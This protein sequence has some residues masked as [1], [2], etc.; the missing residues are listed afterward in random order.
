MIEAAWTYSRPAKGPSP[1]AQRQN[2][3][4]RAIADKARHRLTG[5]YRKL[6][7]RGKLAPVAIAAVARE[8]L[9]FIWAIAHAAHPQAGDNHASIAPG[10]RRQGRYAPPA[11]VA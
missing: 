4:V 5:R 11:A 2:D 9:G 3:A 8:S 1:R 6:M 7:A 10:L